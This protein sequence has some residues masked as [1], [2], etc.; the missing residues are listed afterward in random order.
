MQKLVDILKDRGVT[1]VRYFHADHFEPWGRTISS[2]AAKAV[3]NFSKLSSK[4]RF[5]QSLSLFYHSY[6]PYRLDKVQAHANGNELDHVVFGHRSEQQ[7]AW[8]AQVI[9]PLEKEF[10]HEVHVHIHH[11]GWTR[12]TGNYSKEIAA[13][14]N[15]NSTEELDRNRFKEGVRISLENI[16]EEL[17]RPMKSWAFVHGNWALAGS[18]PSICCIEDEIQI[19]ME[20]GC[21]GDFTF[22]AGRSHCDPKILSVP[23]ICKPIKMLKSYDNLAA[24]PA[25]VAEGRHSLF[26]NDRFLIWNSEIKS[27]YSSLDYYY[28]PNRDR[29][30]N[31]DNM[32]EVWLRKS[33]VIDSCLYIKTH[34][35]S[36]WSEYNLIDKDSYTPHTNPDVLKVFDLLSNVCDK[37]NIPL[38]TVTVDQVRNIFEDIYLKENG[39]KTNVDQVTFSASTEINIPHVKLKEFGEYCQPGADFCPNDLERF[40]NEHTA[41]NKLWVHSTR[42]L[43]DICTYHGYFKS[44]PSRPFRVIKLNKPITELWKN[45]DAKRR[46]GIRYAIKHNVVVR[47][48]IESDLDGFKPVWI[49][50]YCRKYNQSIEDANERILSWIKAGI[51]FIAIE[52]TGGKIIAGTV[53]RHASYPKEKRVLIYSQNTSLPEF[54]YLKPNEFLIWKIIEWAKENG[55]DE[56][57]LAG[58]TLFKSQFTQNFQVV[59]EWTKNDSNHN[60]KDMLNL[61]KCNHAFLLPLSGAFLSEVNHCWVLNQNTLSQILDQILVTS[62][63]TNSAPKQSDLKLF[64]D[65]VEIGKPHSLHATIAEKGEGLYSHWNGVF[66]FSTSNSSDPNSNGREYSL[67]MF[68]KINGIKHITCALPLLPP[69]VNKGGKLWMADLRNIHQV[70]MKQWVETADCSEFPSR[71]NLKIF[72]NGALLG[73]SNSVHAIIREK[74]LG[75]YSHWRSDLLFSTSDNISPNTIGKRFS[76]SCNSKKS[77]GNVEEGISEIVLEFLRSEFKEKGENLYQWYRLRFLGNGF[78][79]SPWDKAVASF[80][81]NLKSEFEHVVDVGAGIGQTSILMASRGLNVTAI[82]ANREHISQMNRLAAMVKQAI[83]PELGLHFESKHIFF[84][85]EA[86]T[87]IDSKTLLCFVDN[88]WGLSTEQEK[89]IRQTLKYAGGLI[90]G[91]RYFFKSRNPEEQEQLILE[92]MELGFEPPIEVFRSK[93]EGWENGF[94][95]NRIVF[96]RRSSVN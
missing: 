68:D 49:E 11:E 50:G 20:L 2:D 22:P 5:S 45:L 15:E 24:E 83:V 80:A 43:D 30:K 79:L 56:F 36:M 57:N 95:S 94:P 32:V 77:G 39:N 90:V 33:V 23:Y 60:A 25:S 42:E 12:N 21:Y 17:G 9:G 35:H 96:L 69:F 52:P 40:L 34:A 74:G 31:T 26:A 51:L 82:E 47:L 27:D 65:F 89:E 76:I 41:L 62:G 16:G 61:E 87:Y 55:F 3:E 46:N 14:I 53:V 7:K 64:E 4:S 19:L 81:Y 93:F 63:D 8:A 37:A 29:F 88:S 66:Y 59:T 67:K 71:S 85:N 86:S 18:D 38:D 1:Q 48:A 73:P 70:I 10:N 91:L 44:G 54:S 75:S 28:A 72:E 78:G 92:L 6:L 84:P 58:D 13:W